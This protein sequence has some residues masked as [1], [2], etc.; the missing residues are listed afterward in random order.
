MKVRLA[1]P[2]EAQAVWNI[3]NQ[4]IRHGCIASY[5]AAVIRAWTPDEMPQSQRRMI[6]DNP[7]FVVETPEGELV[8]TGFLALET[9]SVEAIFT[10]PAFT[11]RGLASLILSAI[12]REATARG[13]NRLTLASTPNAAAFYEKH[14]FVRLGE[15]LYPSTLAKT[16]LRCVEMAIVL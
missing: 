8:A 4:A 5:E 15:S 7:F 1:R 9:H 14:G 12:K 11:G 10:L 6:I 2:E 16:D 3:R 13:L